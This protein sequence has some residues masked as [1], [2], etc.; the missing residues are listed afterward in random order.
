MLPPHSFVIQNTIKALI[1]LPYCS[2]DQGLGLDY[3]AWCRIKWHTFRSP[4]Y[5]PPRCQ[6]E[7]QVSEPHFTFPQL[8]LHCLKRG[9]G[10]NW[11]FMF[12]HLARPGWVGR[13]H[14]PASSIR[15]ARQLPLQ[16]PLTSLTPWR[17]TACLTSRAHRCDD[18]VGPAPALGSSM[19]HTAL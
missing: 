16:I 13:F 7:R 14:G 11:S 18:W 1:N 5:G 8:S 6:N 19:V 3:L 4:S 10:N 2:D 15:A 12:N 17:L 9:I